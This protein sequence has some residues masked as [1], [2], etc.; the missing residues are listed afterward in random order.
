[1]Y[2]QD[3][4]QPQP[5]QHADCTIAYA[6]AC[7]VPGGEASEGPDAWYCR[8]HAPIH[9]FCAN[10]GDH[11]GGEEDFENSRDGLCDMCASEREHTEAM[12]LQAMLRDGEWQ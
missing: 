8:T 3:D 9:G 11:H 2:T 4:I 1:M 12:E 6:V 5:C 7:Y 10:C